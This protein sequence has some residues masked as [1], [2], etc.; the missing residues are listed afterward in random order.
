MLPFVRLAS[1]CVVSAACVFAAS[2]SW[3][4]AQADSAPLADSQQNEKQ[5]QKQ[6]QTQSAAAQ[7]LIAQLEQVKSISGSFVQSALDARGAAAQTSKGTFKAKRPGFFF[8]R[9]DEPLEQEIYSDGQQVV[10]FDPDL[11]QATIQKASEEVNNTPAVLFSGDLNKISSLYEVE[12]SEQ[13]NSSV[14]YVLTPRSSDSLFERL[15]IEF[16]GLHLREM[17]LRDS[18]GQESVIRF[19]Q[20]ELN[21]KLHEQDFKPVFPEGTDIIQDLPRMPQP[22]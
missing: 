14:Q 6:I 17:R 2:P 15:R 18:L 20:T 5:M 16:A 12:R 7:A 10:V 8:W 19:V 22:Q 1:V 3:A 4:Q 13:G 21:P 9:T 11:E